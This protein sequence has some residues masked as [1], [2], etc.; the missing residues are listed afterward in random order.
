MIQF[1]V[2][3]QAYRGGA[4]I[5]GAAQVAQWTAD[6]LTTIGTPATVVD[7]VTGEPPLVIAESVLPPAWYAGRCCMR[8][9]CPTDTLALRAKAVR[10]VQQAHQHGRIL[11]TNSQRMLPTLRVVAPGSDP[12]H[13]PNLYPTEGWLSVQPVADDGPLRI[14]CF[15]RVATLKN[16]FA[17]AVAAID[18][19]TML[20]RPLLFHMNRV[21][22]DD[23]DQLVTSLDV[24]F[25]AHPQHALVWHPWMPRDRFL[26]TVRT[27][28]LMLCVSQ[29]ETFCV[30][31]ADAVSQGVPV[32]VS[33]QVPF[34]HPTGIDDLATAIVRAVRHRNRVAWVATQQL[35]LETYVRKAQ[36]TWQDALPGLLAA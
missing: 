2:H 17:Q 26:E 35:A 33:E 12:L 28:D 20:D 31:A 3:P 7:Q 25:A 15:G 27:M 30:V 16:Q 29:S 24:L 19:A 32:I 11:A 23:A 9:H 10:E 6:Y 34:L 18:A 14:G 36:G 1:L 4:L 8:I 21:G 13:L 5:S 22:V